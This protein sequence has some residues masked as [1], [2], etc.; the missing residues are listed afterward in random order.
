MRP[1]RAARSAPGADVRVANGADSAAGSLRDAVAHAASGD[2]IDLAHLHCSTI[3]LTSG[4]IAIA[5]DSLAM[6]GRGR[7]ATTIDGGQHDRVLNHSGGGTLG[8]A[9]V[10]LAHGRFAAASGDSRG[11]C[12]YS[13]GTIALD[14][15]TITACELS[16]PTASAYG[17]GV[18]VYGGGTIN[19]SSISANSVHAGKH[20]ISGGVSSYY[21]VSVTGSTISDNATLA[22]AR[23]RSAVETTS[24]RPPAASPRS[25]I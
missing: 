22:D 23:L 19:A 5:V 2:T 7:N 11:G 6:R 12:I 16:A 21:T 25:T 8:V 13:T 24:T 10:T 18:S 20:A 3:T 14:R 9:G 15:V 17:G 1:L 4:A